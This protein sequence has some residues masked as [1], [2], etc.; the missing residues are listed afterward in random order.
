M[1]QYVSRIVIVNLIGG[2]ALRGRLVRVDKEALVLQDASALGDII[3]PVD[4]QII[5]PRGRLE[6][7]QV[8]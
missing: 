6:W 2:T 1:K 8:V 4:G 7:L 3:R 5:I